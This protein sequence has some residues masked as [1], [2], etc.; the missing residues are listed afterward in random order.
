MASSLHKLIAA[1]KLKHR[2]IQLKHM[3]TDMCFK[4]GHACIDI[5]T[6][7]LTDGSTN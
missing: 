5:A 1:D 7:V 2:Y 3:Y 4:T 6:V